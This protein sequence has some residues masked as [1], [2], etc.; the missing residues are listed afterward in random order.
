MYGMREREAET[1]KQWWNSCQKEKKEENEQ[2]QINSSR[3]TEEVFE[4]FEWNTYFN[5]ETFS[6]PDSGVLH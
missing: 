5:R 6:L 2:L 1:L 3:D 4:M